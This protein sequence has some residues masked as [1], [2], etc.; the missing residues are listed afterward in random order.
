M[1]ADGAGRM[2]YDILDRAVARTG[3]IPDQRIPRGETRRVPLP[4]RAPKVIAVVPAYNEAA[5][6]AGT[7]QA[8]QQQWAPN[9]DQVFVVPNNCTDGTAR[10]AH[11]AGAT[12]LEFPG[13]NVHKKAGALNWAI[14]VLLPTLQDDD[15]I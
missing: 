10:I 1:T 3:T 8:L 15:Q 2:G 14:G 6:I 13:V 4:R 12:V 9:L 11:A 7:I 5:S